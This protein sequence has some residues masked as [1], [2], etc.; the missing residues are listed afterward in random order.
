MDYKKYKFAI[1]R[2]LNCPPCGLFSDYIVYLGCL[3]K[4]LKEGFI[5][6]IDLQS[7]KNIFNGYNKN[8][9]NENPWENFFN[10]PFGFTLNN[11]KKKGK[12]VRYFQC[13]CNKFMPNSS[14]F[15]NKVLKE[16]WHNI[17]NIYIPIKIEIMNKAN[18][19]I[20]TLLKGSKNILGIL[21]RGTD[22][23]AL[24]PK[25]HAIPPKKEMVIKD[26]TELDKKNKYEFY[27]MAT[28]DDIIREVFIKHFGHKL[29]YYIYKKK[30]N[31]NYK[32]K[33][34]IGYNTNIK[35]N[36]QYTKIYLINIIILS[37]CID[38]ISSRTSGAIGIFI[39]RKR[40]RY[41]KIYNIGYYL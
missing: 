5:P 3:V 19:V 18:I 11:V 32:E 28:E 13:N 8:A 34:L 30:I 21:V 14:I 6:I 38:I 23:I 20:K 17:A 41:S 4:Y 29:K 35:G 40:F 9:L 7:F 22:V 27:F 24:K 12:F 1:I 25:G 33:K 10:Q 36:I 2:R 15:H 39:F 37:K 31:Y 26:I 16:Y